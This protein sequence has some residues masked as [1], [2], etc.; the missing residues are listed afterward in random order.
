VIPACKGKGDKAQ[1][2]PGSYYP[3]LPPL[4]P[5]K[6]AER[7][8]SSEGFKDSEESEFLLDDRGGKE[9]RRK[10]RFQQREQ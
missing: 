9:R 1:I 10:E 4:H 3:P 6:E 8:F 2:N 5:L 7:E